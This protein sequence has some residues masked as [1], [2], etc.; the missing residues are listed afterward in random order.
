MAVSRSQRNTADEFVQFLTRRME[1]VNLPRAVVELRRD[2]QEFVD[3]VHCRASTARE[4]LAEFY[5][6]GLL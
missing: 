2:G 6:S 3:A 1:S 5:W 4:V